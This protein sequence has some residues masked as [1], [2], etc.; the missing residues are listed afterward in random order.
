M[1]LE[2]VQLLLLIAGWIVAL[3]LGR[4]LQTGYR[5]WRMTVAPQ[6]IRRDDDLTRR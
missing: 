6:P 5:T 4:E 3:L 1:P 2:T